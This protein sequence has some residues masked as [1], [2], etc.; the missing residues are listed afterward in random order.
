MSHH[1]VHILNHG[2]RLHKV[3]G[4]MVC[5]QNNDKVHEIPI[6]D[7]QAVIIASRGVS[8]SPELIRALMDANAVI[9]HCD[10]TYRP[11]GITSRIERV[12]KSNA[13]YNQANRTLKL[14][15]RLWRA[16]VHA[17]VTNQ[18]RLL[19]IHRL[20]PAFLK[21]ELKQGTINESACARHYWNYFFSLLG[22][23]GV[24]RHS[25]DSAGLN[26]R[27]NYGYAVLGALVHRSIVAHGLSPVFGMHHIPRYRAHALVYDLMEPWRPYV[28]KMLV[29]YWE[30]HDDGEDMNP[31][32]RHVSGELIEVKISVSD[33]ELKLLDAVDVFVSGISKCYDEKSVRHAWMPEL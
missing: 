24:H 9:L 28:D 17:K 6:E 4:M 19:E 13:L 22:S 5:R 16:I 12:I 11:V 27:L 18:A 20:H 10:H 25:D 21:R 2:S 33:R 15:D 26:A 8:F 14:H 23:E 7:I 30:L 3:R 1:I 32:A 29:E 31:W